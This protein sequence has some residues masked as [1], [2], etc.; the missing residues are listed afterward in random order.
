MSLRSSIKDSHLF[1]NRHKT[2][3]N[4]THPSFSISMQE[5]NIVTT[6]SLN[7]E[8]PVYFKGFF[9]VHRETGERYTFPATEI[10][11]TTFS[12]KFNLT[13]FIHTH[14]PQGGREHFELYMTISYFIENQWLDKEEPLSLDLF[15]Q[16]NSFGLTQFKDREDNIFPYFSRKTNGFCFTVNVPVRS[17]RYIQGSEISA[18]KTKEQKNQYLWN[19]SF[20]SICD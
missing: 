7:K 12:F 13:E 5:E 9:I 2:E 4:L 14:I 20:K 19:D 10:D 3:V 6:I 8:H 17:L 15:E 11:H 18:L 1:L 16:F